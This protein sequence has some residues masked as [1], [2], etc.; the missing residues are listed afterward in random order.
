MG[1]QCS[2]MVSIRVCFA[3]SL[4]FV[5]SVLLFFYGM[6]A[7]GSAPPVLLPPSLLVVFSPILESW[8]RCS[9]FGASNEPLPPRCLPGSVYRGLSVFDGMHP[10]FF[11]LFSR[12]FPHFFSTPSLF[13][14]FL[15]PSFPPLFSLFLVPFLFLFC[16]WVSWLVEEDA[17]GFSGRRQ[18]F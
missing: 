4:S 13:F 17:W 10:L 18:K 12:F 1:A 11:P 9:L 3:L 14:F 2:D 8:L 5:S 7:V 15:F 6:S 16:V